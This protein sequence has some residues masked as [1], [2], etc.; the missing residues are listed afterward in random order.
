MMLDVFRRISAIAIKFFNW[1][2]GAAVRNA[3]HELYLRALEPRRVLSVNAT[4]TAGVLDISIVEDG[5]PTQ[6]SLLAIG[7]TEFFVD[8]NGNQSYDDGTDGAAE[9]RGLIADLTRIQVMG[10]G[11]VGDFFW[12]DNFASAMLL[13]TEPAVVVSDVGS[14]VM[15]ATAL[16][17]GDVSL[18]AAQEV[19]FDGD[20]E[21][22]GRLNVSTH[23]L[24]G[25]IS[26]SPGSS[27]LVADLASFTADSIEL[28]N[29]LDDSVLFGSVAFDAVGSVRIDEDAS[30]DSTGMRMV[31]TN[32]GDEILLTSSGPIQLESAATLH[33]S[34]RLVL[35]AS[36]TGGDIIL[37][38]TITSDGPVRLTAAGSVEMSTL[39]SILANGDGDVAITAENG[40]I[41]LD[42]G[43]TLITDSGTIQLSALS[44]T[45]GRIVLS[46][47]TSN[48][49][50]DEA[51]TVSAYA[52]IEDGT[53]A[54][55]ANLMASR[56]GVALVSL[57]GD[58]GSAANELLIEAERL[59]FNAPQGEVH[60][61]D[62][63]AGLRIHEAS[64]AAEGGN[65]R[66]EHFLTIAADIM[67]GESTTFT[68]GNGAT[69]D[70]LILSDNAVITLASSAP[71][72]LT[73]NAGDNIVIDNGRIQTL[74][75][76]HTVR[77]HA[78]LDHSGSGALDGNRGHIRQTDLGMASITTS[79]LIAR[80]AD[81]VFLHVDADTVDVVNSGP[82][83]HIVLLRT[84]GDLLVENVGNFAASGNVLVEADQSLFVAG[85]GV[86]TAAGNIRLVAG[87][88]FYADAAI[89]A[90]DG[91]IWITAG[92]SLPLD[93]V[94][95]DT[96]GLN[97]RSPVVTAG[98]NVLLE[99][100]AHVQI[101]DDVSS[102]IGSIAILAGGDV[103]QRGSLLAGGDL[104]ID[105]AGDY[106]I[107]PSG[108]TQAVGTVF[109]ESGGSIGL[110][111]ITG[112]H[113]R[114]VAGA[115][116]RDSVG[117]SSVKISADTVLLL[118]GGGIGQPDVLSPDPLA[119]LLSV[120]ISTMR[121]SATAGAGGIYLQQ[122]AAA[123]DLALGEVAATN[124]LITAS[125]VDLTG[126]SIPTSVE[127]STAPSTGVSA[128]DDGNIKIV[129]DGGS[130]VVDA[131]TSTAG[132]V[133]AVGSGDILLTS[134]A[135]I[136]VNSPVS[137]DSGNITLQSGHSAL[138]D[139]DI[140][141]AGDVTTAEGGTL[142]LLSGRDILIAGE[143]TLQAGT[144]AFIDAGRH[145]RMG[146]DTR[147]STSEDLALRA[148]RS[149][150]DAVL[151]LAQA[152]AR[153]V[154]LESTGDLLDGNGTPLNVDADALIM[155]GDT[156][157]DGNG[158][159]GS[160][161]D[162][163]ET[164]VDLLAVR[165]SEGIYLH[166][167]A[168][169]ERASLTIGRIDSEANPVS[170]RKVNFSE[171]TDP[172]E[173]ALQAGELSGLV[174]S[175]P[176]GTASHAIEVTVDSGD[177]LIATV[178]GAVSPDM[179]LATDGSI[180][181]QTR[182]VGN[183]ALGAGVTTLG[184][185]RFGNVSLFAAGW[186]DESAAAASV[187]GDSLN[188]VAS[189]YAHLRT[190]VNTLVAEVGSNGLLDG[191]W[192]QVNTAA[193]ARG[194]DFLEA[195]G[196]ARTSYAINRGVLVGLDDST[197]AGIAR[198][199]YSATSE[200]FRFADALA[201]FYSLF[202]Q[203]AKSLDVQSVISGST[204]LGAAPH[205]YIETL[206]AESALTVE[207]T[208]RTL[209]SSPREGAIVLLAGGDL[210]IEGQLE[211]FSQLSPSTTRVQF[212]HTL[213][214][215]IAV[216]DFGNTKTA[217]LDAR[218]FEGGEGITTGH[219]TLTSTEFVIVDQV[220]NRSASAEDFRTHVFQRVVSQFGFSLEAG[221]VAYVGYA[222]GE[223]QQFDA[224]G[225]IGVRTKSENALSQDNQFAIPAFPQQGSEAAVF[226]RA[227]PFSQS[228]LNTNAVLST[229]L[230][231]RRA[232]DFFLFENTASGD[233]SGIR[234]LTFETFQIDNVV[235]RGEAGGA[236]EMP[237]DPPPLVPPAF[238]EPASR[239]VDVPLPQAINTELDFHVFA[240]RS[241]EV[242][243]YQVYFE[244]ENGNGQAD[245]MEL[246]ESQSILQYTVVGN[247]EDEEHVF[248]LE[249]N[250]RRKI[251]TLEVEAGNSATAADIE[252][253][254]R[255]YLNDPR[256]PSGAYA[257]I[258][259]GVDGI[260]I[261]L[262]V[263]SI[264]DEPEEQREFDSRSSIQVPSRDDRGEQA[265]GDTAVPSPAAEDKPADSSVLDDGAAWQPRVGGEPSTHFANP[266]WVA[267]GLWLVH[268]AH[269]TRA[270]LATADEVQPSPSFSPGARR[271]R[272]WRNM[273]P[274]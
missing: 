44:E 220:A 50:E 57:T 114:M 151:L 158:G 84:G 186:I 59:S 83:G 254:K 108:G 192:Q 174:T 97:L 86:S 123:G 41:V 124:L 221:F 51:I 1:R 218:D 170:V 269:Q 72:V 177:L 26:N 167:L 181:L 70:D 165:S 63:A 77:L 251:D 201:G 105:A 225:E 39:A 68:A 250:Q 183:I 67:L 69:A 2:M 162:P 257:I 272:R 122:V 227:I 169:L 166:Q 40:A 207:D 154:I 252:K 28:G 206:T 141:I 115:D 12:R 241:A 210:R 205:V 234:D 5:G 31:G 245:E 134:L 106:S 193:S 208:I 212:V 61:A 71:S 104:I 264:R 90:S 128:S 56:G 8:T 4:F 95:P 232:D 6:A 199:S 226:T 120:D 216:D 23:A 255:E 48:S 195:L 35:D 200:Q 53:V 99:S 274:K 261:V 240:E 98:G 43:A 242:A 160:S 131:T 112:Q 168:S 142:L 16:V 253:L 129:V 247:R 21:I 103:H 246:P 18:S 231:V 258:E 101:L 65:V 215:D 135:S 155:I 185:D 33:A 180:R 202:F 163:L 230:V 184:T 198:A 80:A 222:D 116:I 262:E 204:G 239:L 110:G 7:E 147:I 76:A 118:A 268:N 82:D 60:V 213:G 102:D 150:G 42:E 139:A 211:S 58:I 92:D 74:E 73:F 36:G 260:E 190:S 224:A 54:E 243:I 219:P 3:D 85:A 14:A 45:D 164:S 62:L 34:T 126:S 136:F 25:R 121:L 96:D 87:N 113:V 30:S 189:L 153:N 237:Q 17:A 13:G 187:T 271:R 52:D 38:G 47:V 175:S 93:A 259:K 46:Q 132:G 49:S 79:A 89:S 270:N 137:S 27:L 273:F 145:L 37:D 188:V 24:G 236:T 179:V 182:F 233:A 178:D 78:D 238:L 223:V 173:P 140:S 161:T 11:G 125:D 88:D 19:R 117:D 143:A 119:N 196:P 191:N 10:D 130:L 127:R 32:R 148:G 20:L 248:E 94:F 152:T 149:S 156:D 81:G 235:S 228:F 172:F 29:Q 22:D 109:V 157:N 75:A 244:D 64:Q 133:R 249:P 100:A 159:I 229:V 55:A 107:E 209:S 217:S 256:M 267:S 138:S 9:L 66:S 146:V 194:D 111:T 176:R 91:N 15:A 171:G 197:P 214:R 263:F 144:D 203:N 265:S 266:V